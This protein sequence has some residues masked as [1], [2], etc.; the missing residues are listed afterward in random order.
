MADA[1]SSP[2]AYQ[3][4]RAPFLILS[5]DWARRIVAAAP[6]YASSSSNHEAEVDTPNYTDRA[7]EY[8]PLV[9]RYPDETDQTD[10]RP[11]FVSI[12]DHRPQF[13]LTLLP[14]NIPAALRA[15]C[16]LLRCIHVA[17]KCQEHDCIDYRTDCLIEEELD[18]DVVF[19]FLGLGRLNGLYV[20]IVRGRRNIGREDILQEALPEDIW[21]IADN[22]EYG[23]LEDLADVEGERRLQSVLSANELCS[24]FGLSHTLS[25]YAERP[26]ARTLDVM[27]STAPC[28]VCDIIDMTV[29]V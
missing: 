18:K 4:A 3:L 14:D 24:K 25:L 15:Q 12:H 9:H 29:V 11:E 7:A 10:C 1:I 5:I 19:A 28:S 21:R 26:C 20:R 27:L 6:P 16:T 17:H 23:E 2:Q 8:H 13:L 22:T